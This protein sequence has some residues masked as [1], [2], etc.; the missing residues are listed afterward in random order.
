M[1]DR[2][3]K[4]LYL[5]SIDNQN[6]GAGA[7]RTLT[8]LMNA[9]RDRGHDIAL[10]STGAAPGLERADRDGIRVW[11]AGIKNIYWPKR[12]IKTTSWPLRRL[13][14]VLDSYNWRMRRQFLDIIEMERPDLISSHQLAGWSISALDAAAEASVPVVQVLHDYYNACPNSMLFKNGH[15]CETQCFPCRTMRSAHRVISNKAKAVVGVSKY[16]LERHLALGYF[17]DGPARH[18]IHNA[19]SRTSLKL[20]E[21]ARQRAQT[22][23]QP[24]TLKFGFI[25]TIAAHKGIE[26]LLETFVQLPFGKAALIIAGAGKSDYVSG[27]QSKFAGP[28]IKFLGQVEP[29]QFF[30][31]VDVTVVP[32]LWQ[33]PL[34]G[35]V[36][37]SFVF[38]VP[39]IAAKRG[40]FPEMIDEGNN[41]LLFEPSLPG[42]LHRAMLFFLN[43]RPQADA[44][45]CNALQSGA[46]FLDTAGWSAKY[47]NLNRAVAAGGLIA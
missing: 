6:H 37:E 18:V 11:R 17:T 29:Y 20:D 45:R 16:I 2:P 25:G 14:H 9:M 43:N 5:N 27:L 7:E 44:F 4:I 33:E 38:G 35:V 32:S 31:Q 40:G 30:S 42:D 13:W 24:D 47:E 41:G 39:V 12:N 36:P 34:A 23:R 46:P 21:A 1:P 19:R 8:T 3:L 28:H 22:P 10:A 26:L 15:D